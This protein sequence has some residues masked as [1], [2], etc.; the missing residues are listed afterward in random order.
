M[1]AVPPFRAELGIMLRFHACAVRAMERPVTVAHEPQLEALYPDCERVLVEPRA[2]KDRRWTYNH[3]AEVTDTWKSRFVGHTV[4]MPDKN[5]R[6]PIQPFMPEPH[7][8]QRGN[9]AAGIVLCPRMRVYGAEKN[10]DKWPAFAVGL[11]QQGARVFVAGMK[12]TSYEVAADE[13]AWDYDRPLDATIEAM[14]TCSLVIATASGLSLLALL[15][16]APLL[17]LT[18]KNGLC[19]PGPTRSLDGTVHHDKYWKVPIKEYYDPLN[20]MDVHMEVLH[21][22]W[23]KPSH[24]LQYAR[25]FV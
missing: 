7:R 18:S 15:C 21:N 23:E 19:A 14:R 24:A 8:R 12:D 13:R 4:E 11:R 17:L 1:I 25:Q 16:G 9:G 10:W 5:N 2:D 20:H 22:A 6:L 3:D